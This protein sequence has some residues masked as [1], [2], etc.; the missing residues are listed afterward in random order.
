MWQNEHVNN[1]GLS[2]ITI[3]SYCTCSHTHSVLLSC[4]F[5]LLI[6]PPPLPVR[7][8]LPLF[9]TCHVGTKTNKDLNS[10]KALN[11][12]AAERSLSLRVTAREELV[13]LLLSASLSLFLSFY[14]EKGPHT[15]GRE[16]EKWGEERS[17]SS[18]H[19]DK[20]KWT[21]YGRNKYLLWHLKVFHHRSENHFGEYTRT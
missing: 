5:S 9:S 20:N 12:K 10:E 11:M 3:T 13:L 15:A 4:S 8:S 6:L 17:G 2:L 19:F 18:F 14:W 16:R 7:L 21:V 1:K